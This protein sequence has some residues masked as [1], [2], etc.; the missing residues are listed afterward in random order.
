MRLVWV[1]LVAML[2]VAGCGSPDHHATAGKP[3]AEAPSASTPA[4]SDS[5]AA[6][7][8]PPVAV[9][10]SSTDQM[11]DALNASVLARCTGYSVHAN[12]TVPGAIQ[13]ADCTDTMVMTVYDNAADAQ[14]GVS[15]SCLPGAVFVVG[16][17]WTANCSSGLEA[18]AVVFALGGRT[19]NC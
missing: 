12:S 6:D 11:R 15:F 3:S 5:P 13:A 7:A 18:S 2:V 17:N 9:S 4:T 14:G 1:V 19:E 10:Y 8:A 16:P